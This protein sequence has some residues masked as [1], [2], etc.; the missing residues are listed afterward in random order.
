[1]RRAVAGLRRWSSHVPL[2]GLGERSGEVTLPNLIIPGMGKSGT[3]SLHEYLD[4][5]PDIFMCPT[6][7]PHF[8]ANDEHYRRGLA[9]YAKLFAAGKGHQIRGESSTTYSL[10]PHAPERIRESLSGVMFIFLLRNPIDRIESHYRWLVV[11]GLE[12]RPFRQAFLADRDEEPDYR[13]SIGGNYRYYAHESRYAEHVGRFIDIFGLSQILV[14]TTERLRDSPAAV[15]QECADFLSLTPFPPVERVW[16]NATDSHR[17]ARISR[18]HGVRLRARADR[19]T[20]DVSAPGLTHVDRA[21]LREIYTP[22]VAALRSRLRRRFDEWS[23][24]FPLD[25]DAQEFLP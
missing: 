13:N 1:M 24:E 23:H 25:R 11:S 4:K 7:E 15:L 19:G 14:I 6:K 18:S 16:L 12:K 20:K 8:F 10:F 17:E 22:E 21:W 2:T 5:H 3:S 9:W